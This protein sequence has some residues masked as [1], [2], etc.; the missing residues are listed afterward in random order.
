MKKQIEMTTI[1][2]ICGCEIT[3]PAEVASKVAANTCLACRQAIIAER[4]AA[5]TSGDDLARVSKGLFA[6]GGTDNSRV[7][8]DSPWYLTSEE[9]R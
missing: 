7:D 5:A 3:A 8:P 6:A 2:A 9:R 4:T 1:T